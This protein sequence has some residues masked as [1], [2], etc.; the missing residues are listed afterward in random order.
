MSALVRLIG[1]SSPDFVHIEYPCAPYGYKL[2]PVI[3]PL[4]L[5]SSRIRTVVRAHEFSA[6]HVLRRL[7]IVFIVLS[8]TKV[9]LPSHRDVA[10]IRRMMPWA[11]MKVGWLPNTT[12]VP[13]VPITASERVKLRD[14]FF[15]GA[16]VVACY[17]GY[18]S[19]TKDVP[20]LVEAVGKLLRMVPNAYFVVIGGGNVWPGWRPQLNKLRN[21]AAIANRIRW[22]K[23]MT[24]AE[25]S[26]YLQ[27]C[28][29][30]L[31]PFTDSVDDRRTSFLAALAH[32]L[33]TVSTGRAGDLQRYPA[34]LVPPGD[35][36][37]F[38]RA[39]LELA[40]D[41]EKRAGLAD[42]AHTWRDEQG[43]DTPSRYESAVAD[44]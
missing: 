19:R 25:I 39:T 36:V 37:A 4:I 22:T 16:T 29:L 2:L 43:M 7:A 41:S 24:L 11:A 44:L 9:L 31:L 32:G 6:A 13:V 8:A 10:A 27:V 26:K 14:G 3:L 35:P 28:D 17:F 15:P 38:L 18:L 30:A 42:A 33:A 5:R 21:D 34:A 20:I 12:S 40:T 23:H 1:R